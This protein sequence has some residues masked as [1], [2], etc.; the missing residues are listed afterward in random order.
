MSTVDGTVKKFDS[1]MFVQKPN[2]PH[3]NKNS[4]RPAIPHPIFKNIDFEQGLY[5]LYT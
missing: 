3:L 2:L 1:D 5:F 4:I